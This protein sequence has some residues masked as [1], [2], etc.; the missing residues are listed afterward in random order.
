MTN[1]NESPVNKLL[2]YYR[3]LPDSLACITTPDR[4]TGEAGFFRFHGQVCYG[5][6]LSG[7]TPDVSRVEDFDTSNGVVPSGPIIRLPFCFA[8]VIDNLRLERYRQNMI[9]GREVFA[10]TEIVRRLYYFIRRALPIWL[11]RPL[12]KA[13]FSD[14]QHLIFP[15]WPVDFT[16]DVLHQEL[17]RLLMTAGGVKRVPFIWFW[18][19]GASGCLMMTHDVETSAGRDFSSA[20]MDMDDSFGIKSSF[21]VVPEKRY[22]V[23]DSYVSEVRR[24]GFE[25]NLHDLNHD[26]KL[27][28]ERQEFE[29]RAAKINSYIRKYG[30]R[31]FRAGSMYRRQD[32]YD[33]FQFSYDMSVPNVARLEPMRGGCCTVM[34]YF[35]GNIVELP[36]TLAQD[37][38]LFHILDDYSIDLWKQQ[39]SL[40]RAQHGLMSFIVHPDYVVER[41]ARDV[42]RS[43]LGYLKETVA[44]ERIWAALPG[45]VDLWWRA[46]SQMSL[47]ARGD[48]WEIM[49]PESERARLAYATLDGN[50]LVYELAEVPS[51]EP[52]VQ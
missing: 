39:L 31:G 10:R 40:I 51:R 7:T 14:W 34:P 29:R 25:L 21:Q 5:R 45:D 50:R 47:L 2:S 8:E 12:Q 26:G 9:P 3:I 15:S 19:K 6:N 28:R 43:L 46:R 30:A 24:R 33:V 49:G 36:L 38:S 35:V 22:R 16:V 37:Y 27:Y 23:L 11:R 52:A 4:L 18:P 17:L 20:L 13:Y 41:R 44:R 32:W 1:L 42:Y 48:G